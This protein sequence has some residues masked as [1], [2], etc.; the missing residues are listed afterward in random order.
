[1]AQMGERKVAPP[2]ATFAQTEIVLDRGGAFSIELSGETRLASDVSLV[3]DIYDLDNFVHP[4]GHVGWWR[5]D[6]QQLPEHATGRISRDEGGSIHPV[7]DGISAI[8]G[9]RN[10]DLIGA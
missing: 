2:S 6:L 5:Y 4:E 7:M 10:A 3:I 9:W 8:D 1:M